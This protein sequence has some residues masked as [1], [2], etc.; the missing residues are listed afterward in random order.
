M[1]TTN[2]RF[3][4]LASASALLAAGALALTACSGGGSS[5]ASGGSSDSSSLPKSSGPFTYYG[6]TENTTNVNTIKLL[7][8]GQCAAANKTAPL[9]TDS[10]AGASYDQKLQLLVGQN[11]LSNLSMASGTPSLMKQFI[12]ANQVKDVTAELTRLGVGDEILP[13]AASVA[14]QL[15]GQKDVYVLPNEF[16]I[17]GIWYNKSLLEKNGVEV[18]KTWDELVAATEKL[19]AAGVQP[20]AADGKD[21]WPITRLVGNYI[22]RSLGADA[23]QKVAD[24]KA[25]LTDPDYV[26]AADAVAALG[27]A[28]AFGKGV[29]STDYNGAMNQ[30]LTGKAAMF[31][32]GSWALANFNDEKQNKVGADNIGFMQFPAVSGGAGSADETPANLGVPLMVATKGYNQGTAA[33][34]KCIA[35]NYGDTVLDKFGVISGFKLH[36][37]H[38]LPA[39]TQGVQDTIQKTSK[40]VLRF[41]ALLSSKATT[42]SQSNGGGL[43][44]GSLSGA[45]FMQK[46]QAANQ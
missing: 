14:K 16:N 17:E 25:K 6:Q 24:G 31:Y 15:H 41:E 32:M 26:K 28:G 9:K 11:S 33:W 35:Q 4:R 18:P 42:V 5:A 1:I 40:T 46:V 23:L 3:R 2:R 21:G 20:M 27:K 38:K 10:S 7:A 13:A 8:S 36:E 29:A 34:L 43:A 37:T 44:N 19:Q 12:Q 22:A 45:D 30:F 39:L